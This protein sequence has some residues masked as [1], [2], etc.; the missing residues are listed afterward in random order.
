[1]VDGLSGCIVGLNHVGLRRNGFT[2][3][4]VA[5]LK[6]AYRVI[7]RRGLKWS[8]VLATLKSEFASGPA[9]VFHEFLSGGTRGF[10][11]ERR[12]PPGATIKFRAA[13]S[14]DDPLEADEPQTAAMPERRSKAG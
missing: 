13:A 11:Q 8:D 10:V 6:R 1:M 12:V 3:E 5:E 9:A 4:Q 7:Y 2:P 14:A